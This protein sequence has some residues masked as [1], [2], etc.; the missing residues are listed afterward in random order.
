MKKK[1]LPIISKHA[2]VPKHSKLSDKEKKELLEKY[3]ITLNELPR[4]LK[5]DPAINSLSVKSGDIVK[6]TRSSKTAG[7]ALF[8][9]G[10]VNV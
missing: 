6:I 1:K 4:I 9:R 8:Y 5:D 7:T 2:L 3:N 10:V